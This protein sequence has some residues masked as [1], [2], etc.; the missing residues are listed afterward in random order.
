MSRF[1]RVSVI[2]I[3]GAFVFPTKAFSQDAVIAIHGGGWW[4]GSP[5]TMQRVCDAV[6]I[7]FACFTPSY[8]LS[9]Q[10]PFP[11][12]NYDLTRFVHDLRSQGYE[13]VYAIG[14]S[15]GGNLA[16]WLAM[17]GLVDGAVT[18]SA[19]SNLRWI[20]WHRRKP[21][22]VVHR[23]AP[24]KWKRV[25]ASPALHHINVPML[26]FHSRHEWIPA[27][28]AWRLHRAAPLSKLVLLD[29]EAHALSYYDE[30][31]P[32]TAAWLQQFVTPSPE[33]EPPA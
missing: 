4:S 30:A 1:T 32:L 23:F 3:V 12:A 26:I 27:K 2:L 9:M 22:W 5:S 11:A 7:E 15:A 28:Q 18:W 19:P 20:D 8:T 14:S 29:G 13:H 24:G 31:M 16:A 33:T 6:P 17:R 21:G 25:K 10:R